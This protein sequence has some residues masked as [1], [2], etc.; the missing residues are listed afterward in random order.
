MVKS[1]VGTRFAIHKFQILF[2]Y[3]MKTDSRIANALSGP[4]CFDRNAKVTGLG[5]S[6]RGPGCFSPDASFHTP[7]TPCSPRPF[8]AREMQ[9]N[10]TAYVVV[11]VQDHVQ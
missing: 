7:Q 8:D 2:S 3:S 11:P 6:L 1:E 9:C 10:I 5:G 4:L